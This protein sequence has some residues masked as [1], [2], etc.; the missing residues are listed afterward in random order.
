MNGAAFAEEFRITDHVELRFAAI[1]ALD[2]F[3]HTLAGFHRDGA[4]IDDDSIVGQNIGDL[5]RD[6]FDK[7]KIDI[8]VGLGRSGHRDENDLRLVY[9]FANAAAEM[10]TVRGNIAMN[11]FLQ[12]RFVNWNAAG[13]Q[14]LNFCS[15]IIDADHVVAD[16]GKTS[17]GHEPNVS[18]TDD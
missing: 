7:A 6:F 15:V 13:L 12:T 11:D 5:A 14:D 17:A 10:Q 18:G 9:A 8:S 3:S 4:L 1:V 16:V 2:R